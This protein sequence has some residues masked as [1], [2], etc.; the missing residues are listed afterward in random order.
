MF[1]DDTIQNENNKGPDQSARMHRLVC[2]FVV[3][4]PPKRQVFSRGGP[5]DIRIEPQAP[6]VKHFACWVDFFC[7]VFCHLLIAKFFQEY[8]QSV[9]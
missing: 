1:R 5:N 4:K 2:S 9:K 7:F 6:V 8:H 3:R